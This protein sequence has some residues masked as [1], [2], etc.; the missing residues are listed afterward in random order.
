MLSF[1]YTPR[2][3]MLYWLQVHELSESLLFGGPDI[4]IPHADS[5]DSVHEM[6]ANKNSFTGLCQVTLAADMLHSLLTM[7]LYLPHLVLNA[8]LPHRTLLFTFIPMPH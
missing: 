3:Q 7:P 2:L 1:S 8:K 4:L 6:Q 5:F